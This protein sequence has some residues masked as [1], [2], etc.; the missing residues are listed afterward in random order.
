MK[1]NSKFLKVAL[2]ML[3]FMGAILMAKF[4]YLFGQ[5]LAA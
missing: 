4:G 1:L 3:A 5:M 2:G